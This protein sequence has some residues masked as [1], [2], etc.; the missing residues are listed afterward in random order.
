VPSDFSGAPAELIGENLE[1]PALKMVGC[2]AAG[3]FGSSLSFT[4][5]NRPVPTITNRLDD[6]GLRSLHRFF[7]KSRHVRCLF[8][9]FTPW[10]S[11]LFCVRRQAAGHS[12][13]GMCVSL[14]QYE[15]QSASEPSGA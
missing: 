15:M 6:C 8:I 9:E 7:L 14:S 11:V 3:S 13:F 10:G 12:A 4:R 2:R 1:P 5:A